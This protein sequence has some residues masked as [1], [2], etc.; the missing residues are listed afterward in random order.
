[1]QYVRTD[2]EDTNADIVVLTEF[3]DQSETTRLTQ[4]SQGLVLIFNNSAPPVITITNESNRPVVMR[5]QTRRD[6]L[7]EDLED[8]ELEFE[9]EAIRQFIYNFD[10]DSYEEQ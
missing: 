9:V 6:G 4:L 10:E 3:G 1:V 8:R 5:L 7:S 2:F